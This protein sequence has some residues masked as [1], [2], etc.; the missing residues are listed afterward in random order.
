MGTDFTHNWYFG[1]WYNTNPLTTYLTISTFL[2]YAV[3]YTMFLKMATP[4]NIVIGGLSGAMPPM[5]GWC[6]ITASTSACAWAL[7]LIIY[8]WTPPHFWSL[9]IA[10]K[11]DYKNAKVPMLPNTHGVK[12][13]KINIVLYTLLL[14]IVTFLPYLLQ[15]SGNIYLIIAIAANMWFLHSIYY[16]YKT[17]CPKQAKKTFWVSIYYLA[18]IF[19]GLGV[20]HYV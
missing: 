14:V 17:D 3:I 20:D 9:A 4:Q 19:L 7:V 11:D 5:L 2:G 8:T 13:T 1:L 16:L 18:L 10:K 12:F 15:A 6:A